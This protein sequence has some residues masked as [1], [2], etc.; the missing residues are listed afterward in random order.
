MIELLQNKNSATRFEILVQ[1]AAAGPNVRQRHVAEKLGVTPQAVSEYMRRLAEEGLIVSGGRSDY[2]ISIK[3]VNWMLEMLRDLHDY[4]SLVS[5]TITNITTCAAIAESD[6]KRGQTVGLRMKNGLLFA[7]AKT[8]SGATGV[9]MSSVKAGNDVDITRIEGLVELERGKVTILQVPSIRKGGSRNASSRKLKSLIKRQPVGAMGI[10]AL[11]LLRKS[12]L[13]PQ[14]LYGV[15]EAA[16]EAARCGLPFLVVCTSDAVP[17]LVK[18]LQED[19]VDYE[20][21]DISLP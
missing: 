2:R 14:Y 16:M 1:V 13:E 15:A 19:D 3:G 10:E 12:G 7:T 18:R 4:Y 6:M 20:T 8:G 21:V 9:S 17:G 5:K 11:V